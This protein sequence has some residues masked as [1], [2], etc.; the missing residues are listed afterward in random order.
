MTVQKS[1]SETR[2]RKPGPR[3]DFVFSTP[4]AQSFASYGSGSN[5]SSLNILGATAIAADEGRPK[6]GGGMPVMPASKTGE[7]AVTTDEAAL[8]QPLVYSNDKPL[9]QDSEAIFKTCVERARLLYRVKKIDLSTLACTIAMPIENVR[10]ALGGVMDALRRAEWEKVIAITGLDVKTGRLARGTPHFIF[11]DDATKKLIE[12]L[13][14]LFNNT[15]AARLDFNERH[16]LFGKKTNRILML[17]NDHLR[18]VV[19]EAPKQSFMSAVKTS[20]WFLE[21]EKRSVVKTSFAK[22]RF[23]SCDM[24]AIDFDAVFNPNGALDWGH[25]DTVARA[26]RVSIEEII[27]FIKAEGDRKEQMGDAYLRR[28]ESLTLPAAHAVNH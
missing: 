2:T 23:V 1:A 6:A 5:V 26:N 21:T 14:P 12:T 10:Q 15:K 9:D 20:K 11:H 19:I 4:I 16:R 3:P 27:T 7:A 22:S 24:S 18:V 28:V 25:V 8:P 17:Q 13:A